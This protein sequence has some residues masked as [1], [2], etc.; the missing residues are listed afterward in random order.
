M[1]GLAL[2]LDSDL[3]CLPGWDSIYIDNNNLP[4]GMV[5]S[6]VRDAQ[7][8]KLGNEYTSNSNNQSL[9]KMGSDYFN[10]GVSL[11]DCDKW[12]ELNFP[13][14]WPVIL[15]EYAE[16][17][18]EWQDQCVLN[19]ICHGQVNYLDW[20]YNYLPFREKHK[21]RSKRYILHFTGTV[22]PW[23]YSILDPRI[24]NSIISPKDIYKYLGYQ[25]RLI[26]IVNRENPSI[27]SILTTEQKR[28]Q[29][30][31][32]YIEIINCIEKVLRLLSFRHKIQIK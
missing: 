32:R 22:K 12:K 17:G 6:A 21:K 31:F 3:L 18:F 11:F 28:I 9:R 7:I 1:S 13:E 20:E 19:F 29:G 25:S 30:N 2:W 27:G 16:R 10:S 14:T 8:Y 5:I 4:N 26:K 24:L 23:L 15:K